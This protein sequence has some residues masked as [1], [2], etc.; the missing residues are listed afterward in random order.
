MADESYDVSTVEELSICARWLNNGKPEEHFLKLI[1]IDRADAGTIADKIKAFLD[2]KNLLAS[3]I[4]AIGLDG[5]A[6]MSVVRT[7]VQVRLRCHSPLAIYIHCR[8]HQ[9]QLACVYAAKSI[10]AVSRV[11]WNILAIW[12]LFH[13]SPK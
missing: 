1:P 13:Y 5:A 11:Q 4:R 6:A 9:L 10:K 2:E 12:K 7:G 3:K 8:C